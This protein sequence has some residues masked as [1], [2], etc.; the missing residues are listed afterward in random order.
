MA[1]GAGA[2]RAGQ[3][4]YGVAIGV[5]AGQTQQSN[6]A[7]AIGSYAG[8]MQQ[9]SYAVAIGINTGNTQ[10][11]NYAVAVGGNAGIIQQGELAVAIGYQAGQSTQGLEAVAVGYFAGN[12]IQ[13]KYAVAI[14]P[15]AGQGTQYDQTVAVGFLAGQ[16]QQGTQA[17]AIG[18]QAGRN[19]QHANSIVINASGS[20]TNSTGTSQCH[21]NPIRGAATAGSLLYYN[22]SSYEVT[23]NNSG[24]VSATTFNT[25]SDYRI[26]ENA[27]TL[28]ETFSLDKLRP[29][30][31]KNLNS[32]K[33]DIGLIAHE[34][35]E[36]Y[37]FLVTGEKDGQEMQTVNYTGLIGVLVKEI[38]VLSSK[39][40][41]LET[42]VGKLN[43]KI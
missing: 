28:D 32:G 10:Q 27:V 7:I 38:H 18:A 35:Q 43:G 36:V 1:I 31:Y 17:V 8:S 12:N 30:T 39:V 14:G 42:Q 15:N 2:G 13:G 37:P 33:Q 16:T 41:N 21:I 22:T 11:G 23:Y 24:N 5:F 34:L 25:T 40:S 29:V 19:A 3:Q 26:K 6:N 9:G 20:E 4:Y